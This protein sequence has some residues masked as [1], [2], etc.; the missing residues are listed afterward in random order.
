MAKRVWQVVK[1][2]FCQRVAKDVCLEAEYVV[3][4]ELLSGERARILSHRCYE[5][6]I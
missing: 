1:T 6:E 3:P 2:N 4:E 5:W